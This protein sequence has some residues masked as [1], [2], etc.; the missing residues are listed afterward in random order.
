MLLTLIVAANAATVTE[1]PP[2]LRGDIVISYGYDQL[3]GNLVEDTTVGPV[4]VG[5][6]AL[7]AHQLSYGAVF[8]AGP[9]VAVFFD[10]PHYIYSQVAYTDTSVMVFDPETGSGTYA[11]TAVTETP[12]YAGSGLGGVWLGVRGTPF[13]EEFSFRQ[14]PVT[15]LLEG[16]LRT[17]HQT[18]FFDVKSTGYGGGYGGTALR[19]HTAFSRHSH[20]TSP[21]FA[22]T[23]VSEVPYTQDKNAAAT[24]EKIDPG[25]SVDTR[26]GVEFLAAQ[27]E[28]S[29]ARLGMDL[30]ARFRYGSWS[31]I[32]SGVY[33]PGVLAISDGA[34]VQQSEY[35][36]PGAGLG[37]NWRMFEYFQL[38]T[39]V[40]AAWHMPQRIE[41]IYP[42]YTGLNTLRL[43][44]GTNLVI[45]IR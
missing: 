26:F 44:V 24:A 1:I 17:P 12:A 14:S 29:G 45:R 13:S 25:R 11:D 4:T 35:L 27:S 43:N 18:D 8:G 40:D 41:H 10:I 38:N 30:H 22:M 19:L 32:P 15:W 39:S 21:Y 28:A 7:S 16:A 20:G 6:R 33:L 2:F 3:K 5:T 31:V 9:G 23:F 37:L 34:L 36:E 42:V